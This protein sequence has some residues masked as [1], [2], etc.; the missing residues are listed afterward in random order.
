MEAGAGGGLTAWFV[1]WG[2]VP[3]RILGLGLALAGLAMVSG[4][5]AAARVAVVLSDDSEPYQEVYQ[6]ISALLDDT[7]HLVSRVYAESVSAS[8]LAEASLVVAVGV[9]AAESL[10]ARPSRTPVLAVLVPRAWYD[11]AG[12]VLLA[13][14]GQRVASAI[15]LDQPFDRQGQLIRLAFPEM[16]RVGALMGVEQEY[17]L[18]ELEATLRTQQLTLVRGT[19]TS[20]ERLIP[21]L[22]NVLAGADVLL[23]V[24]DPLV[25]N[26][27]TAQSLF[28]TSYRYRVPVLGYSR[29]LTRAGA[30][31]SLHS[32]P[33]QIGRQTAAWVIHALSQAPL[34]LPSP[35]YP[36]YFSISIN[37]Q[38][39]RSLGFSLPSEAE[40]EQ[41]LG[42]AR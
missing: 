15:Y 21:P 8:S 16:Q 13:A 17:L 2:G 42:G 6:V 18:A 29:S 19:L 30:L 10:A 20:Q 1:R 32:S 34:R 11:K 3:L 37:E 25:F 14:G 9:R 39:A 5:V 26:R 22:E 4:P 24:P 12:R 23:A 28:L 31:L 36:A 38:V 27:N 7:R 41:R 33:A 40:L 35:A